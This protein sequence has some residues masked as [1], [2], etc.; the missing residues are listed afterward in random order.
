MEGTAGGGAA[1]VRVGRPL[2]AV[3]PG[4][5]NGRYVSWLVVSRCGQHGGV[6]WCGQGRG[7]GPRSMEQQ[8]VEWR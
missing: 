4:T 5:S 2:A 7:A 8:C 3:P 1:A 6:V